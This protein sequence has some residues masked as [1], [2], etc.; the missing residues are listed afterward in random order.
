VGVTGGGGVFR[1]PRTPAA[2]G[3]AATRAVVTNIIGIIALDALF[4]AIAGAYG[5]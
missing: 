5:F 3:D 4:A 2:V 1:A